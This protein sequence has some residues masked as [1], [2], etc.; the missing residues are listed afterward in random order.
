MT[1]VKIHLDKYA[2]PAPSRL[3]VGKEM[4]TKETNN[5]SDEILHSS[6]CLKLI[7]KGVIEV[8]KP[9]IKKKPPDTK[10]STQVTTDEPKKPTR[11]RRKV[12]KENDS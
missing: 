12:T 1:S 10:V 6:I 5:L 11:R 2:T 4:L 3:A 7:K 9:P 8:I